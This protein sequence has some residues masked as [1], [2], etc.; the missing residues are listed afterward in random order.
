MTALRFTP[1]I[2]Q[3]GCDSESRAVLTRSQKPR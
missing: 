3:Q 1:G 2:L